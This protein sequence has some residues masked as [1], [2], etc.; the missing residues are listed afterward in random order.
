MIGPVISTGPISIDISGIESI[1]TDQDD[2]ASMGRLFDTR[3]Q[4]TVTRFGI[5]ASS[6]PVR[7][8]YWQ[9]SLTSSDRWC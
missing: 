5:L 1:I 9:S 2:A 6:L 4:L 8:Y 7:S 3:W